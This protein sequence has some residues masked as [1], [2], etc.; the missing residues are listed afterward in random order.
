MRVLVTGGAGAIGSSVVDALLDRGDEVGVLDSF[1]DFYPRDRKERN[2]AAARTHAGFAGLWEGDIRDRELVLRCVSEL[3]PAG[4]IH[5]AARAGVPPSLDEPEEYMD[6]NVTG[7]AVVVRAA[8]EAEVER[9]VFASSSSVYGVHEKGRFTEDE[10]A[11]QPIS[12]YGASKRAAEMLCHALHHSSGLPITG[13]R[14]FNAYGPRQRPD[15]ALY[16]FATRALRGEPVSVYGDGSV[17][18]DFTYITDVVDGVLRAL[19][20]ADGYRIYN[21]GRGQPHSVNQVLDALE[22]ALGL[23]IE[24]KTLPARAGDVPRTWASIDRAREELGYEPR[25]ELAEGIESFLAWL[26]REDS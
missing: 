17:E 3:R 6:C 11:D 7:T 9:L 4:V 2:L 8:I 24:R 15:L 19:D 5:L 14:F 13:L 1:H 18:R 16:R 25:V 23:S 22:R 21:L 26:R 12:P 10:A 20:R